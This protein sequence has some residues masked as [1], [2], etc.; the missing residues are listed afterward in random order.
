MTRHVVTLIPGDGIG[1]ETS[2]AMQRVV[3]AS[4]VDIAWEIALA[5]AECIETE[6]TPLPESTLESIRRNG[7]AIKGPI[8]TPVAGGFRS[9]NVALR[10]ALDLY[11]CLRPVRSLPGAGGR[12]EDVDL[13]IVRENS[14]DLYAGIEFEQGSE[15]AGKI[16]DLCQSVGAGSIRRDSGISIKPISVTGSRRIVRAAFEYALAQGRRKVTAVHKGPGPRYRAPTRA[17]LRTPRSHPRYWRPERS[18]GRPRAPRQD[19]LRYRRRG[20]GIPPHRTDRVRSP[21]SCRTRQRCARRRRRDLRPYR[22]RDRAASFA[23]HSSMRSPRAAG[24]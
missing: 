8:A 23:P 3:D 9:V 1:V 10:K 21:D 4:G 17:R 2:A 12:Y 20:S 18:P 13:V 14:E 15:D 6:G 5:G 22:L 11:N 7:V 16:I 19:R 24:R